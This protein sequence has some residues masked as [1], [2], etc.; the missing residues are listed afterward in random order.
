MTFNNFYQNNAP[1][2][3][4]RGK[5]SHLRNI[6]VPQPNGLSAPHNGMEQVPTPR[7]A[8]AQLLSG[9]RTQQRQ[10]T[11]VA[12]PSMADSLEASRYAQNQYTGFTQQQNANLHARQNYQQQQQQQ[13]LP[14]PPSATS[15][16]I[17]VSDGESDE[18]DQDQYAQLMAQNM[19][20]SQIQ[21]QLAAAQKVQ[22]LQ[23]QLAQLQM[24]SQMGYSATPPMS[25]GMNLNV[26]GMNMYQNQ[27]AMYPNMYNQYQQQYQNQ[28]NGGYAQQQR[29]QQLQQQ[30]LQQQQLEQLR[31]QQAQQQ[32]LQ[33]YQRQQHQMVAAQVELTPPSPIE[34]PGSAGFGAHR[35]ASRSRSPPKL[36]LQQPP[37]NGGASFRRHRKASSL[38]ISAALNNMDINE[39]PKTA[40]PTKMSMN[41]QTPMTATFG[42]GH[43]AGIHPIRQPRGPPSIEE[44]KAKP[45]A[46][47]EGS[48]NFAARVRRRA[49]SKLVSAGMERRSNRS[50]SGTGTMTP[51]SEND[52][53]AFEDNE[54]IGSTA[55]AGRHSRQSQRSQEGNNSSA[56]EGSAGRR[57]AR[58][59]GLRAPNLVLGGATDKRKSALF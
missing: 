54:S 11:P 19:Y 24:Q 3:G 34:Q 28:N 32:L 9:L 26:S 27:A 38:S 50:V 42:P 1:S 33:Q 20:L 8:R 48:Q 7:S 36:N 43:A 40:V 55:S 45:T 25:P 49:I 41:P 57:N 4:S 12:N 56:D 37:A 10:N 52:G 58:P 59:N 35:Q 17:H 18:L 13:R 22:Q 23:Q 29:Q 53:F 30:Q 51:V 16:A 46:N 31:Q 47:I 5:A 39:A 14:T 15:P 44:L 21:Q 2:F 6:T